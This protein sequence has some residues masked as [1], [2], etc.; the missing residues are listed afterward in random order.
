MRRANTAKCDCGA[1]TPNL[2]AFP[3]KL[4]RLNYFKWVRIHY[5]E[6]NMHLKLSRLLSAAFI[7][8]LALPMLSTSAFADD[9]TNAA[10]RKAIVDGYAYGRENLRDQSDATPR[11]GA[12]HFWSSGGLLQRVP[13]DAPLSEYDSNSTTPKHIEVVTLQPGKSAV[14]MYYAEGSFKEKGRDAVASYLTR[15]TEVF[16]K[17]GGKWKIRA[18]H[19]SAVTGGSG[20]NQN[21]LD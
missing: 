11:D 8:L 13:A 18:A 4:R 7:I 6:T 19:Y 14:A 5:G 9:K 12:L 20:T 1:I 3:A 2:S 17:E 16:V 15:V 21:A 10:V